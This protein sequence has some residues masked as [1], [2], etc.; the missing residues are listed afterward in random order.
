M[1]EALLAGITRKPRTRAGLIIGLDATASQ[2]TL[3][4]YRFATAIRNVSGG[5]GCRRAG[6]AVGL[7]SAG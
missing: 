6:R 5:R 2:G 3:L 7:L 1:T 4:G